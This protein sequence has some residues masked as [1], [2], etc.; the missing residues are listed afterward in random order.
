MRDAHN[1]VKRAFIK[2]AWFFSGPGSDAIVVDLACGRGGDLA[3]FPPVK[4]YIAVDCADLGL[5]ELARRHG[6]MR[7][8]S[9]LRLI[10]GDA[11]YAD[12]PTK[13]ADIVMLNFALHYFTD[14]REHLECLLR[15]VSGALKE[16]GI[17]CG[18]C[19]NSDRVRASP[20]ATCNAWPSPED[21]ERSPFGH[22]YRY[23]LGQCV[24]A[25]EYL[26]HTP[27]FVQ[28]AHD[29]R[30]YLMKMRGFH[31]YAKSHD[32]PGGDYVDHC[33]SVF[34]FLKV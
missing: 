33:H 25:F 9:E 11:A 6:E 18:T 10:E 21:F 32:T 2:E 1:H 20:N 5:Q 19:V 13:T 16:G 27:T 14:T 24:D 23:T 22:C 26:V 28:M 30:L 15:T 3:K 12:I 17:F 29:N 4:H 7:C 34:M 8:T 31:E